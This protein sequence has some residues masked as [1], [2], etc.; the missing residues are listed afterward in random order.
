MSKFSVY[1]N[2][3]LI[4][5]LGTTVMLAAC[6][7]GDA[8]PS[9]D[10][11][12]SVPVEAQEAEAVVEA[13][14]EAVV[15]APEMDQSALIAAEKLDGT[16]TDSGLTF[17][18][19]EEG[20]GPKP[21]IGQLVQVHYTGTLAD[22]TIFDSSIDNEPY[23]FKLGQGQ[24]IA[25]WDEGIAMLNEGGKATLIIPP[26][27]AYGATGAGGVIPPNATLIFDVELLEISEGSTVAPIEVDESD[28]AESDSGL[29]FHDLESGDGDSPEEGSTV[30]VHYTGWLTDGTK[31]DSS[32][33]RG[34]PITFVLGQGQVIAG[35]DEGISTMQVGGKRQLM[36]PPELA[37]AEAGYGSI[38]PP[39]S[40][41]IFEVELVE[42]Q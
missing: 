6:R 39:N 34:A 30:S 38:I 8:E 16:T 14:T 36:I 27:L 5:L 33:D 29:K 3:V 17:V 40:T 37:Y 20:D 2:S 15:E 22:G 42:V 35:W 4:L 19:L 31:F 28:F 26:Q 1:K 32:Y 11:T 10:D 23:T 9:A 13:V 21:E 24:V 12:S 18:P 7:S 41:L 25:G